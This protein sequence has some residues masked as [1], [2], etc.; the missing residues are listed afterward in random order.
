MARIL[1]ET[2]VRRGTGCVKWDASLPAGVTLSPEEREQVIPMWVADMD[3]QAAPVIREAMQRR[4]DHGVFG[5]TCVPRSC[6][7][8]VRSWFSRRHGVDFPV[9]DMIYTTGVVPAISA[10]IKALAAPGEGV[11]IQTPV[12]NCFFSCIRNNGC[13]IVESPLLR[14]DLPDGRFSFDMDFEDLERKCASGESKIL[15][16]CNPH[17]PAGRVWRKDELQK[18]ESICARHGVLVVSDEIHC[19]IVPTGEAYTPFS[20]VSSNGITLCSPSKSFNIAGLQMAFIVSG[21]SLHRMLI[22]KAININEICDVNP[23]APVAV[24]AAYSLEGEKWL[25]SMNETVRVNYCEM[26]EAFRAALPAIPVS[27]LEGTYLPWV[28]I[29]SLGM[30]SFEVEKELLQQEKVWVNAGSMYGDDRFIR[31]NLAT[32]PSIC[33]EGIAR[34]VKGLSRLSSNI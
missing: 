9:S 3:F 1:D 8:A 17:N 34:V 18:V 13:K 15:L 5:Y 7:E 27:L 22:D 11:I 6:F 33:R 19:E 10:V 26:L 20:S 14:R 4:M 25:D 30:P 12:Y 29:S 24:E 21:S 23:F 28:D 2:I 16:L 32:P 31:I